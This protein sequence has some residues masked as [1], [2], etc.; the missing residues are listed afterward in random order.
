[1]SSLRAA[2]PGSIERL[3][4]EQIQPARDPRDP[5][6]VGKWRKL[7]TEF[8]VNF[9]DCFCYFVI[10]PALKLRGGSLSV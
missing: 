7:I 10:P 5:R 1:V 2:A 6:A 8:S 4:L 3:L 9:E